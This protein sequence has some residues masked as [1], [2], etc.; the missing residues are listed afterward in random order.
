MRMVKCVV[1]KIEAEGL[2]APP[3]PG[4]LGERIYENVSKQGW[5]DWLTRLTMIINENQL[6]TADPR[7]VAVIEQHMI[8]FL[9]G[10][11]EMGALPAGFAPAGGKK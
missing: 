9:F 4:E 1:K 10:E 3:Y 5:L 7:N 6:S 2:D 8:G 11:S